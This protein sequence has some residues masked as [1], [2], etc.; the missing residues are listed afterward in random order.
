MG[1]LTLMCA[2]KGGITVVLN[3]NNKLI[4]IS[5]LREWRVY[6][7]YRKLNLWTDKDHFPMYFMDQMLDCLSGRG[8]FYF[9]DCFRDITKSIPTLRTKRKSFSLVHMGCLCLIGYHSIYIMLSLP[10]SILW[11]LFFDKVEDA[12]KVFIDDFSVVED[13]FNN[14]GT[15]H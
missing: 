11:C 2:K 9:I 4:P 3:E 8:W 7:D 5:L 10:F 15:S 13:S 1:E 12:I 14:F 6:M